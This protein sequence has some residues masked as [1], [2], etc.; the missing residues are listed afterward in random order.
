MKKPIFIG[1]IGCG[2]TTLFQRLRGQA[3]VYDKTQ[4]VEF[5][6]N[7][8]M[9]DTPGEFMEHR[10]LYSALTITAVDADVVVF[11]Q[12]V[13]DRRQTFSPGFGSMFPKDKIGIVTKTDLARDQADIDWAANQLQMAGAKKIF[14]VSAKDNRG[15]TELNN[16]LGITPDKA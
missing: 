7:N 1:A 5:Y 4:V 8:Q 12:S 9:I 6:Q 11:L 15:I 16:Y 14:Y 2:K 3:L 10:N 13:S